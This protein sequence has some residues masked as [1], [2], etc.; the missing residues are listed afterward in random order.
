M[1]NSILGIWHSWHQIEKAFAWHQNPD[2][3]NDLAFIK[4]KKANLALSG[5]H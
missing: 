1:P 2:F 3:M 5:W 4:L